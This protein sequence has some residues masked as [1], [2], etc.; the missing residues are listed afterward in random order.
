MQ[1]PLDV[2]EGLAFYR[3]DLTERY[4]SSIDSVLAEIT[5]Q[6]VGPPLEGQN[7]FFFFNILDCEYRIDTLETPVKALH[8]IPEDRRLR[9]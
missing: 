3:V 4:P 9:N 8:K 7:I 5:E 1:T 6:S 2:L